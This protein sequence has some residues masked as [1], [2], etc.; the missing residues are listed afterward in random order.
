M[1]NTETFYNARKGNTVWAKLLDQL[2]KD[3]HIH[4]GLPVK[5]ERHPDRIAT[6]REP[7][8]FDYECPDGGCK[9][10]W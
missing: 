4:D 9:E 3:G 1:G 6:L 8:D 7:S 10:P 2:K 5:C